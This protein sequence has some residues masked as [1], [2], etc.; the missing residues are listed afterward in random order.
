MTYF[1][2][3]ETHSR[4]EIPG[5]SLGRTPTALIILDGFGLSHRKKANAV[6]QART[7]RLDELMARYPMTTLGTSG[8]DVGLVEGQMGDSNVGHLNLGAGQIVYQDLVRINKSIADRSFFDNPV[9]KDVV[10]KAAGSGAA[11]HLM[12]LLS[13]GGVHSHVG[14]LFAL[15]DLAAG[16]GVGEIYVHCFL[17][18]RDVPPTSAGQYIE[19]LE[20]KLKDLGR[21]AIAT[22]MGRYYAMDRDKR[23][24]RVEKAYSAMVLGQGETAETAAEAV[25]KAYLSNETD[26][27][28]CPTVIT[29]PDGSP[30]GVIKSGDSVIFYN[31]RADRARE[32]TRS[33]IFEDFREFPRQKGYFPVNFA[34]MAR[35][36][37]T[38]PVPYAFPPK[39]RTNTLGEVVADRGL[40]QLRIAETEKY[41]HVTFFF[42]GGEEKVFPGEERKLI[43]SPKVS[44]YDLKPE[45]S[46]YEV[47]DAVVEA[48]G[49]RRFDLIVLNHAHC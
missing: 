30:T 19:E 16:L 29:R 15:L 49:G 9:F 11:L 24:D 48:I 40:T 26:E 6:I 36:D 5:S 14:H 34:G 44:T 31:Y 18:G 23:W 12:G 22:V 2:P 21:G 33:L 25:R 35:Y 28:V 47:T 3:E 27:F 37:E 32:I 43:P 46:A 45:M 17:D 39:L 1:R 8:E 41:A 4:S 7:P 38:F 42:S 13:N 10:T 20:A